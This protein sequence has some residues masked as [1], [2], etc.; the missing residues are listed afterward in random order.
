[1]RVIATTS[2]KVYKKTRRPPTTKEK[3]E[4]SM[5]TGMV[6]L[7]SKVKLNTLAGAEEFD[8][9]VPLDP[10]EEEGDDA[11]VWADVPP[12]LAKN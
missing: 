7:G 10:P 6:W 9:R 5:S 11:F 3:N 4:D 8:P 2:N 1:M 12:E